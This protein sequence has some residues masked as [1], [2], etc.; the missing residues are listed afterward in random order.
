MDIYIDDF[1][2]SHLHK[3]LESTGNL[4]HE[5]L[6]LDFITRHLSLISKS[7]SCSWP[8]ILALAKREAEREMLLAQFKEHLGRPSR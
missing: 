2:K 4:K 3:W 5:K 1:T 6:M 8:E 7:R